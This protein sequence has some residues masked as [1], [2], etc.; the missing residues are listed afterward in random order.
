MSYALILKIL[1][2]EHIARRSPSGS[3]REIDAVLSRIY[4]LQ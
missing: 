1:V 4:T 3:Y 2:H